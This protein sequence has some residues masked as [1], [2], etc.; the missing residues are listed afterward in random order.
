MDKENQLIYE[1]YLKENP[2]DIKKIA[3]ALMCALGIS[4][5]CTVYQDP[6]SDFKIDLWDLL[7]IP[8]QALDAIIMSDLSPKQ[9]EKLQEDIEK[10]LQYKDVPEGG[11]EQ[12]LETWK[13]N[14]V[15]NVA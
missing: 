2:R 3:L 13:A 11:W 10:V 9:Q 7:E 4:S 14:N 1:A 5:G 15:D 12:W 8:A 6:K